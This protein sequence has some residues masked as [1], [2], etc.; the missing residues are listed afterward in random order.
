MQRVRPH[1]CP[2]SAADLTLLRL[3]LISVVPSARLPSCC[4]SLTKMTEPDLRAFLSR[5]LRYSS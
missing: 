2:V 3:P 1:G 5:R 4:R